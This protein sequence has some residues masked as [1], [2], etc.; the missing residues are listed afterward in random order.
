M[1]D[2]FLKLDDYTLSV[3]STVSKT[4]LNK[5]TL[6][7]LKN[8]RDKIQAELDKIDSLIVE[9]QNLGIK[10]YVPSQIFGQPIPSE[11]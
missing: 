4:S 10:E 11:K 2:S 7:S 9:A 8:A 5:Y 3:S 1:A 6:T